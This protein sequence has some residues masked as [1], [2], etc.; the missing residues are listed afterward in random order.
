MPTAN[1]YLGLGTNLGNKKANLLL[2]MEQIKN[3]IGRINSLSGF[4]T[5]EPWGFKSDNTFLNA[6]CI[7][8]TTHTPLEILALI[9]QIEIELGRQQKSINGVYSDR[10][11]DIDILLY[12]DLVMQTPELT[13]PHPLMHQRLFV[14]QPL[15]EIASECMHPTLHQTI[16][17]LYEAITIK[18]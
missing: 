11:I 3:R 16:K 7:V 8:E 13:I 15:A 4:Y 17:Q 18:C 10:P 1:V 12:D 9:K 5:T 2:A 14:M 6:A